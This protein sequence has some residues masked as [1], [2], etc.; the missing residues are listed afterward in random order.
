LTVHAFLFNH[1]PACTVPW[2]PRLQ[3]VL[4]KG[5]IMR[6]HLFSIHLPVSSFCVVQYIVLKYFGL[7]LRIVQALFHHH[8]LNIF[9]Q[10]AAAD[11]V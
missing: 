7:S 6:W 3:D 9:F 11:H 8:P 10:R 1:R 4:T 2:Y 5:E